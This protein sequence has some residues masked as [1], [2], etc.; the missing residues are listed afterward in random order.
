V[1]PG[2]ASNTGGPYALKFGAGVAELERCLGD[3][4][5]QGFVRVP[6]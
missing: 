2:H 6:D 3:Y 4:Q 1:K 5:R